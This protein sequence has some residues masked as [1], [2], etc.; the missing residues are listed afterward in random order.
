MAA[1]SGDV[2]NPAYPSGA[3]VVVESD[4]EAAADSRISVFRSRPVRI[5]GV[6]PSAPSAD[7]G[8]PP[9]RVRGIISFL[10]KAAPI[11]EPFA[12]ML[13][14]GGYAS[15]EQLTSA[16][17]ETQPATYETDP[18]CP[19]ATASIEV[20]DGASTESHPF[21]CTGGIFVAN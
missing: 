14:S 13:S 19:S 15:I 20:A 9:K 8:F 11:H 1:A 10:G 4:P 6:Q 5:G 17:N 2:S 3:T 21:G 7:Y 18:G 12:I 16:Y